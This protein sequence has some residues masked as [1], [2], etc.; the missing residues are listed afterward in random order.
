MNI[1]IPR[2]QGGVGARNKRLLL[3]FTRFYE[4][5]IVLPEDKHAVLL[6]TGT[7]SRYAYV[8]ILESNLGRPRT[9]VYDNWHENADSLAH[10][11]MHSIVEL[12]QIAT[13]KMA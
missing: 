4:L 3:S 2:L 11:S 13:N 1:V 9:R 5:S 7:V 12:C 8:L 6:Q 10:S